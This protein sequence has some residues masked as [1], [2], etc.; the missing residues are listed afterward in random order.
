MRLYKDLVW[1]WPIISPH[2]DYLEEGGFFLQKIKE[3]GGPKVKTILNLGSGGGD[4]DWVLKRELTMT[5]IDISPAMMELA[6]KLNP[7]VEYIPD[8]MRTA[9]L[10]RRF[11]AVILHDAVAHMQTEEELRAAFLTA[12]EHLD[13]GGLFITFV[14]E[15][16]EHFEQ[17]HTVIRNFQKD[18]LEVTYIENVYDSNK[19]DS[20]YECTF[21]YLIRR[22]GFPDVETD[23]MVLGIF[24][25]ATWGNTMREIG[26]D[27]IQIES[28][29][30][31][32]A[33]GQTD[34]IYPVL[35]GIKK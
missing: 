24:P 8:D 21:V 6:K 19:S 23:R 5:G 11:D 10:N 12:Y 27:V 31:N 9:R 33:D 15:W 30:A 18:K 3:Y 16:V 32:L 4:I 26:F 20:T 7:E 14:E 13:K 35:I 25:L 17:N 34:E 2:E 28:P 29:L 1:L 22:E